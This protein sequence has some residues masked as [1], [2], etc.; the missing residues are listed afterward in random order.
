MWLCQIGGKTE[1]VSTNE[2]EKVNYPTFIWIEAPLHKNFNNNEA[3]GRYNRALNTVAKLHDNMEVLQLNS[4]D[5]S[6][7]D[8]ID[9]VYTDKGWD[10]YW[11]AVDKTAKFADTILFKKI[12]KSSKRDSSIG[13]KP[14]P[15]VAPTY[16]QKQTSPREDQHF[17]CRGTY[18]KYH[19]KAQHHKFHRSPIRRSN[20]YSKDR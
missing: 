15:P 4:K 16:E 5:S 1:G 12:Q 8:H 19:W 14:T 11:E 9:G 13:G 2:G 6:L 7:Y 20:S 3:R 18:D 17:Y 10:S